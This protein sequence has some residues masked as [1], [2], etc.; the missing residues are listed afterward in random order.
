MKRKELLDKYYS[1]ETSLE[2][3]NE[4]KQLIADSEKH[5]SERDM[6]AFFEEEI[7]V[8]EDIDETAFLKLD[9]KLGKGKRIRMQVLRAL[10]AAA[11]IV[12]ILSA[13]TTIK[14]KR[15]KQLNNEFFTMEQALYQVSESIQPQEQEDMLVLWVNDNVEIIIH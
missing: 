2:E 7:K 13:Y 4:L 9:K 14:N 5:V 1:G 8:P 10:S 6:F 3:E 15:N 11:V 12:V